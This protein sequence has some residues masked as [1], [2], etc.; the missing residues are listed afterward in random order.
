[1]AY[2]PGGDSE[3]NYGSVSGSYSNGSVGSDVAGWVAYDAVANEDAMAYYE[4]MG[5]GGGV[6]E[7]G[8]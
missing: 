8:M 2:V 3:W 4:S 5:S 1:M 6:G 7:V